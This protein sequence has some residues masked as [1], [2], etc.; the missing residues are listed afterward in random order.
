MEYYV[1][2]AND[3]AKDKGQGANEIKIQISKQ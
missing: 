3:E 2:K 1:Y